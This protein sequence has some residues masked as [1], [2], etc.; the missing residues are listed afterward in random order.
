MKVIPKSY[1]FVPAGSYRHKQDS[2]WVNYQHPSGCAA[3]APLFYIQRPK[4]IKDDKS[5]ERIVKSI[6]LDLSAEEIS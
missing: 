1:Q 5:W 6:R 3:T 2:I 4:W